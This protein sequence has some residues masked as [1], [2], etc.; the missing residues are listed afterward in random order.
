MKKLVIKIFNLI[1]LGATAFALAMFATKD[2]L[3]LDVTYPVTEDFVVEQ[4]DGQLGDAVTKQDLKDAFKGGVEL[5]I[6]VGITSDSVIKSLSDK[7]AV[8]QSL[9][10]S[11]KETANDAVD[12]MNKP[13]KAVVEKAAKNMAR[14]QAEKSIK[15]QIKNCLPEGSTAADSL[16]G[17]IGDGKVDALTNEVYDAIN[18]GNATVGSIV[19]N[20]QDNINSMLLDIKNAEDAKPEDQKSG[21]VYQEFSADS[22]Q[23]LKIQQELTNELDKV[24]LIDSEGKINDTDTAMAV[25]IKTLLKTDDEG[26]SQNRLVIKNE[27]EQPMQSSY[28]LQVTQ[29]ET[30]VIDLGEIQSP[31]I[32][33]YSA[34]SN[35]Y[36]SVINQTIEEA[37]KNIFVITGL[38]EGSGSFHLNYPGSSEEEV[39]VTVSKLQPAISF[40]TS[41]ISVDVNK[42]KTLSVNMNAAVPTDAVVTYELSEVNPEGSL[43]LTKNTEGK[44]II[45]SNG[46]GTAKVTAK[47]IVEG[48]EVTAVAQVESK[49]LKTVKEILIEFIDKEIDE[50]GI[51]DTIDQFG[52]YIVYGLIALMVPWVLFAIITIIRTIRRKKCWTKPWVIFVFAFITVILAAVQIVITK[53][54]STLIDSLSS[55]PGAGEYA[56]M[57]GELGLGISTSSY[58]AGL[59]YLAFIPLTIVYMI[60]CHKYKKQY[61]IDKKAK[62]QAA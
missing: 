37:Q 55:I 15:D 25:I 47:V 53:F 27:Q 20:M 22:E 54:A 28:N 12:K 43:E 38:A 18:S 49:K 36:F 59:V 23:G 57:I 19:V 42:T 58:Y 2:F 35:T 39:S 6:H 31:A 41:T 7:T 34:D 44:D 26:K 4:L 29:S 11:I 33:E 62:K 48:D 52:G 9:K 1:F 40:E 30:F 56:E 46:E 24:G 61:K 3:S 16:Y 21:F 60:V 17:N 51:M 14:Q 13:L 45:K 50:T 8:T 32:V 5:G 10:D